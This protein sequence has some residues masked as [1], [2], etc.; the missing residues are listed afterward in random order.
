MK[1][2]QLIHWFIFLLF[3][4]FK[5]DATIIY[6]SVF[7]HSKETNRRI[8]LLADLH[9]FLLDVDNQIQKPSLYTF[10]HSIDHDFALQL[11]LRP[12]KPAIG[13]FKDSTL[14]QQY[15]DGNYMNDLIAMLGID[16][17]VYENALWPHA[18]VKFIDQRT[19]IDNMINEMF[20]AI[21]G[22]QKEYQPES[23]MDCIKNS[24]LLRKFDKDWQQ[25]LFQLTAQRGNITIETCV[26][27]VRTH[28]QF[29]NN[30]KKQSQPSLSSLCQRLIEECNLDKLEQ[31]LQGVP[32]ELT[33]QGFVNDSYCKPEQKL[34]LINQLY[35]SVEI[36]TDVQFLL[37]ILH[38]FNT[39]QTTILY[40]GAR[41][42]YKLEQ[43]LKEL[44]FADCLHQNTITY[45]NSMF[46]PIYKPQSLSH[47]T[48][49]KLF[50]QMINC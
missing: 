23:P 7:K 4:S 5:L 26:T 43:Y 27:Q 20:Y 33:L 2:R 9:F 50:N 24:Q 46:D 22:S 40:L 38:S 14:A 47:Q 30:T 32:L 13:V 18:Q 31:L 17:I 3:F 6:S 16:Y 34:A 29:L 25:K 35:I 44:G 21:I 19:A 12:I 42:I 11:E 28:I 37:S 48:L 41:H 8:I 15:R 10:L 45:S 49:S 1:S 39:Y 36:V